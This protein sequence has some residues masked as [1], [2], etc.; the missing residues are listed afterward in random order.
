MTGQKQANPEAGRQVQM[1]QGVS[2]EQLAS[3]SGAAEG[4]MDFKAI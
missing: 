2:K 1:L 4:D 3:V